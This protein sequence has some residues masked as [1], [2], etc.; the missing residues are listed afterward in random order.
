VTGG[1][2]IP[3]GGSVDPR[4]E[5][6]RDAFV[7]NFA[8]RQEVGA[9][10]CVVSDGAVVA[11]LWGGW[12]DARTQRPWDRDS[13]VD[14]FSVGKAAAAL[15]VA[16]L[17]GQGR[18]SYDEPV[19]RLWP[20][21]AAG[22]KSRVTVRQLLSHQAGLPAVRKLLPDRIVFDWDA[23]C[24]VLAAERPWWMAG[25]AHGYHANTFGFL[26]G[27]LVRRV[28]G[29]TLG[30]MLRQ[31]ITGPMAADFFIGVPPS[32]LSRVADFQ[33]LSEMR[34]H[35]AAAGH[36]EGI[37]SESGN[38]LTVDQWMER[39]AYFNPS[40]FSGLGV[41]NSAEWRLA[42]MPSTNGRAFGYTMNTMGPRWQNP[43]NRALVDACYASL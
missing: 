28:S 22:D 32:E 34:G 9:A 16:R 24:G 40:T 10:L 38:E 26:V 35:L 39:Q 13:L 20:E 11:D 43:R 42:E 8:S 18:L 41:I 12:Q 23:M 2:E 3:I 1:R 27:E 4:F 21:F 6:V 15:C 33:G 5:A 37:G 25:T 29:L 17:V 36:P 31:E 7:E 30:T 14:V 19:A